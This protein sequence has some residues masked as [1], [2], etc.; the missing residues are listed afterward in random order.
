MYP[1]S[2][3]GAHVCVCPNHSVGRVTPMETRAHVALAGT[4]GYELDI[5]KLTEEEKQKTAGFNRLY[6]QY[7]DLVREGDYYRI[8]SYRENGMY[9]C[10]QVVSSD[11]KESLVTYVQVRY[12]SDRNS[13][14]L[15][16]D[17]LD[18]KARYRLEGTRE[19][20]SGEM[21]MNAGFLQ[22]MIF[23]DYGSRLLHFMAENR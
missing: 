18:P 17:G 8:A 15:K 13:V 10:W 4:F 12:E 6:H 14:R 21:L 19:I 16:L 3:M 11:R 5:T 2:T 23:G 9:D 22:D 20:Y 1:L 7:N